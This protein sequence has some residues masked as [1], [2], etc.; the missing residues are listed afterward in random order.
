MNAENAGN[1]PFKAEEGPKNVRDSSIDLLRLLACLMVIGGHVN[2]LGADM[3]PKLFWPTLMMIGVTVFFLLTG[4]TFYRNASFAGLLKKS[5]F[6][7]FLPTV[8]Y[9]IGMRLLTPMLEENKTFW[10]CI[11]EF[12]LKEFALRFLTFSA[13]GYYGQ[14]LW[15][16]FTYF[17]LILLFPLLKLLAS[18]ES[19]AL[20]KSRRYLI[21]LALAALLVEDGFAFFTGRGTVLP[22]VVP[23]A[24]LTL[25]GY[26][27]ERNKEGLRTK[28]AVPVIAG[29]AFLILFAIRWLFAYRILHFGADTMENQVFVWQSFTS[30]LSAVSL[31][32]FVISLRKT[33]RKENRLLSA[34]GKVSFYVYLFH[35]PIYVFLD[36]RGFEKFLHQTFITSGNLGF[37]GE[38]LYFLIRI[39]AVF[40]LSLIPAVPAYFLFT[41]AIPACGAIPKR[42]RNRSS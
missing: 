27:I 37:F 9:M 13:G 21:L 23:A 33:G 26:E 39:G 19:P 32:V 2:A 5:F 7:L 18:E 12:P 14:H 29:A 34:F 17:G 25:I 40:A 4:M 36:N 24:L 16:M 38:I 41:R 35:L 31:V 11:T 22:A 28:K 8:L 20:Q 30:V 6:R 3:F 10:Q 15:Y 1:V 42:R